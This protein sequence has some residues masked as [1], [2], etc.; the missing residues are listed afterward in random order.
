MSVIDRVSPA[1]EI[2]AEMLGTDINDVREMVYQPT[3]FRAPRVYSWNDN[4]W[5]YFCCPTKRQKLPGGY[6]WEIV[7]YS[8]RER[9]KGRPVYGVRYD[10]MTGDE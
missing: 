7:G 9:H 3:R 8:W 1:A 6:K 10:N 5:S 2:I 4:P